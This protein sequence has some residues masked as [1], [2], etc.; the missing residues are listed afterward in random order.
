M[1][2]SVL[3]GL[4]VLAAAAAAAASTTGCI[5]DGP[6]PDSLNGSNFT[7]PWP[8]KVF[9]FT[10]QLQPLQMAFMDVE[11]ACRPNGMTAVLLHGKNFCGPTW[12]TTMHV[13]TQHG[14]RVVVPDQIGF[15]KSSK[16]AAYQFSLGQMASNTRL[17]LDMLD[18]GNVTVIGH[19]L[20]GMM[21]VR[22][23]LQYPEAVDEMVVV[24]P[25]GLEDYVK[26]G[27]PYVGLD[28]TAKSEAASG[29]DSIRAYEKKVYYVDR[30]RPAYETWV[31]ML[32]NI[33]HGSERDAYVKNQAQVVDMVLTGPVAHCFGDIQ[34]RTLLIVGDKDRTAIGSQWSSPDVA[35][36]LGRFDLLGPE[37]AHQ[38]QNGQLHRFTN[39]GHAPQLSD[40]NAFHDVVLNFLHWNQTREARHA[41]HQDLH[42]GHRAR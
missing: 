38:L 21:A 35:A 18:V 14:Y 26:K 40:P 22:I 28:T 29:Y 13:L 31:Q 39:L 32:V 4:A 9:Q 1:K 23:A 17:L 2:R 10:S 6:F 30:W 20:G 5:I 19:S 36:K 37:A 11:P 41:I 7:Y 24:A 27:V 8:V 16:P 33:Y 42:A 25:V 3:A 34:P 12:E 15:C